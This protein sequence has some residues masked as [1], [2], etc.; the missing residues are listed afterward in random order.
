M[1]QN[2]PLIR[3]SLKSPRAAAIAGI[4]FAV[5][6]GAGMVLIRLAFSG[7]REFS[8][9]SLETSG[10]LLS[11]AL[12]LFPFAGIAFLWFIGVVRDHL[13]PMED[14]LF[15]TIFLGSGLLFLG[16]VFTASA[17]AGGLITTYAAKSQHMVDD[18]IYLFGQEVMFR[19]FYTYAMRMAGLSMISLGTIWTRTQL[20]PRWLAFL[21]YALALVLLV[22]LG[23][24]L[25]TTLIFPAW[26]FMISIFILI[27]NLRR[28]GELAQEAL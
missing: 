10:G 2:K 25:W 27:L 17:I 3:D 15:S 20:M 26:V 18:S 21:T 7:E 19:V 9:L 8:K 16:M 4:V 5:L 22:S 14:R 1:D 23:F 11:L 12:G 13:G 24:N 6:F 28:G